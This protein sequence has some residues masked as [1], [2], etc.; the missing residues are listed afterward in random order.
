MQSSK[1]R[2]II[3]EI[4]EKSIED[5]FG[6]TVSVF[7]KTL[8]E[9]ES[10]FRDNPFA[11]YEDDEGYLK[12]LSVTFLKNPLSAET[13]EKIIKER[14]ENEDFFFTENCLYLWCGDGFG[15]SKIAQIASKYPAGTT[16]NWNSILKIK[17]A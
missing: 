8:D 4:V 17:D 1:S 5:K 16:R 9:W 11:C 10:I 12:M 7:V 2:E 15:R 3:E 6:F 14:T 13:K